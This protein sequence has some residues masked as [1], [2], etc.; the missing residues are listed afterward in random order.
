MTT[1]I[2]QRAK[3]RL[4]QS[5]LARKLNISQQM[6]SYI[7]KKGSKNIFYASRIAV[8]FN[9]QIKDFKEFNSKYRLL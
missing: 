2:E 6:L 8:F 3:L 9:L 1:I 4:T 5:E 7:E